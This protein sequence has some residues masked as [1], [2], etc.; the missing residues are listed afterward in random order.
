[1]EGLVNTLVP[2]VPGC[3]SFTYLVK[4]LLLGISRIW[5]EYVSPFFNTLPQLKRWKHNLFVS[6]SLV[7]SPPSKSDIFKPVTSGSLG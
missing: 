4:D 7:A 5:N 6:D 1:M 2:W 3:L